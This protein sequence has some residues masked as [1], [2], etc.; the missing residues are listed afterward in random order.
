MAGRLAGQ[1]ALEP[2][3]D[4][5]EVLVARG[6]IPAVTSRSRTW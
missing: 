3:I 6:R 1:D 4:T 2:E 5:R